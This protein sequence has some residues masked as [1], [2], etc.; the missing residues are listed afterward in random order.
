MSE[1]R[2]EATD[3]VGG[4]ADRC[5]AAVSTPPHAAQRACG[6]RSFVVAMRQFVRFAML[7]AVGTAAHYAVLIGV[8]QGLRGDPLAGSAAGCVTG[9][10]VNYFLSRRYAFRSRAPHR[11]ALWRFALIATVGLLLNTALMAL[12]VRSLGL[13]YLLAQVVATGIVLVWNF[14]P[15][16]L[17]TFAAPEHRHPVHGGPRAGGPTE[18]A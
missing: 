7:G 2:A 9:M 13:H 18:G 11:H 14:V 8:V 17:W 3:G 10:L 5:R 12:L 16:A 1:C 6:F 4:A 15:N